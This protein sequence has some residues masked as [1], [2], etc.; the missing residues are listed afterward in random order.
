MEGRKTWLKS[1]SL[2]VPKIK[3]SLS[4]STGPLRRQRS[5]QNT[6]KSKPSWTAAKRLPRS[7][8]DIGKSNA[9]FIL[10][11][12]N[13]ENLRHTQQWVLWESGVAGAANKD[14]WVFEAREDD[15]KLSVLIPHLNHHVCFEYSEPWL[16]YIRAIVLSYD[17]SHVLPA[18][19]AGFATGIATENAVAGIVAGGI[20]A[21]LLAGSKQ[22]APAGLMG[23]LCPNCKSLYRVHRYPA[24]NVMRCPV[25]N[26]KLQLPYPPG[27]G[28]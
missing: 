16:A 5:K 11:G 24:W 22:G 6:R 27:F 15:G 1:S 14:I 23:I 4:L 21:L 25:C 19:S 17:D 26:V 3:K 20:A 8:P 2:T 7:R 12:Q 10:L 9:V 18:I 28:L 13:I